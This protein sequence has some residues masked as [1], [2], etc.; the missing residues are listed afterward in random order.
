MNFKKKIRQ[1]LYSK[2]CPDQLSFIYFRIKSRGQKS[3]LVSVIETK[4]GLLNSIPEPQRI[5]WEERIKLVL[6]S[7]NNADI[8]RVQSAGT[9]ENKYLV[10]HN[11][12]KIDSLSYYGLGMTQMLADNLGVH[13][14]QEEYVF[15]E[16]LAGMETKPNP[17]MLE[18]GSY[19][20]F[21][22]MWMLSIFPKA[23]C[24]MVE[25]DK[26]NLFYGRKNFQING[27]QGTF[28]HAGIG[29][30]R[31]DTQNITSVDEICKYQKIDF[32]DVLHSDIQGYELEMLKGSR[33]MLSNG[34]VGYVFISTHS[35]ELHKECRNTLLDYDFTEVASADL[36]ESYSWDGILVMRNNTYKGL[37]SVEIDKRK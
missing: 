3:Q 12:V 1:F 28:I 26:K 27:M 2:N 18:L 6:S 23:N 36:D 9:I 24:Y 14:P 17:T 11:G 19:W 20:S 21:Y 30:K 8:P 29:S 16:V 5:H 22:S 35:N 13:E 7:N 31:D 32:L 10:M 33:Q 37:K 15:Q 34:K 4:E 25:P